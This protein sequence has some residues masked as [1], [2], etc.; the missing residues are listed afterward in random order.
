MRIHGHDVRA[1]TQRHT[2]GG[3]SAHGDRSALLAWLGHLRRAPAQTW[4]VHGEPLA[5]ESLCQAIQ[6]KGWRAAV[7][8]P[9]QCVT[10]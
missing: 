3:L 10:L 4:V 7:P 2:I 5:A 9:R 1:L 6:Q 8:A